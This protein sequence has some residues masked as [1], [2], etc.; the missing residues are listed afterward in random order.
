MSAVDPAYEH[1]P[2]IG[3]YEAAVGGALITMV[4]PHP[5]HEIAYNRWYEDDHYDTGALAMFW[6]F[7]GQRWVSPPELRA[8]RYPADS[9]VA[10]PVT[11]GRYISLSWLT[12]GRVDDH[13]AWSIGTNRR[14]RADARGFEER[15]HVFTAF[16]DHLGATSRKPGPRD[17]YVEEST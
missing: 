11:T 7:A 6:L 3:P 5:G 16:Q 15:T 8:L 17:I 2:A 9:A 1:L 4:E 12:V 14:L 10:Q 13:L